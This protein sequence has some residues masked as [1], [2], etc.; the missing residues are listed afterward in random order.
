MHDLYDLY[1]LPRVPSEISIKHVPLLLCCCHGIISPHTVAAQFALCNVGS[2]CREDFRNA[3]GSEDKMW[4]ELDAQARKSRIHSERNRLSLNEYQPPV[5]PKYTE[6][7]HHSESRSI[8]ID[9]VWWLLLF[10]CFY[11][12][13]YG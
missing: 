3:N 1:V 11:A 10:I 8:N 6:V 2:A 9:S 4:P 7:S 13:V 5:V 12:V